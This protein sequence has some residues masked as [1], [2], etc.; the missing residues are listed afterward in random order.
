M[1][2]GRYQIVR[3]QNDPTFVINDDTDLNFPTLLIL[4]KEKTFSNNNLF[5]ARGLGSFR[6]YDPGPG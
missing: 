6:D 2:H 5:C 1:D 4:F 3:T